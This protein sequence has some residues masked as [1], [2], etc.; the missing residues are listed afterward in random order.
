MTVVATLHVFSGR[1]NPSWELSPDEAVELAQCLAVLQQTISV[2]APD[3]P[4]LGYCGFRVES[5]D[6]GIDTEPL[7]VYQR[8]VRRGRVTWHDP[9]RT[10]E[11]WLLHTAKEQLDLPI[12]DFILQELDAS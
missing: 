3:P 4:A 10:L 12:Q 5:A 2:S 9:D 7:V 8:V 6:E 11:R 1:R